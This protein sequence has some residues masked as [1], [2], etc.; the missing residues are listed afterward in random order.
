M[1]NKLFGPGLFG[2]ALLGL[3]LLPGAALADSANE[4]L[5]SRYHEAAEAARLCRDLTYDQ[6]DI[7][8]M[9]AVIN[10]KINH[11]IGAKRLSLLSKAKRD[12]RSLVEAEGCGDEKVLELLALF[13]R[14]LAPVVD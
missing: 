8:R 7:D 4:A 11:D 5:Y 10:E 1:R 13:D 3:A 6:G 2:A 9:A 12:A 14:D